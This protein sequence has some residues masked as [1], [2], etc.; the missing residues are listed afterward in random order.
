MNKLNNCSPLQEPREK[1]E[2]ID[3]TQT[4]MYSQPEKTESK[5]RKI[6]VNT[7]FE[8]RDGC[9]CGVGRCR[10]NSQI[11]DDATN[12]IMALFQSKGLGEKKLSRKKIIE[13]SN[14]QSQI[15]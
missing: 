6:I 9:P 5:I 10:E 14:K 7:A 8:I 4:K 1:I 12:N 13:L 3:L 15:G 11:F 2:I